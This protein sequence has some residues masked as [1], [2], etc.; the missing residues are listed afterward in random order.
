[1]FDSTLAPRSARSTGPSLAVK[2]GSGHGDETSES[3]MMASSQVAVIMGDLVETETWPWEME[4][5]SS[6]PVPSIL[7]FKLSNKDTY[8][9]PYV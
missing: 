8:L 4:K 3:L 7:N 2:V 6:K 1:M 9:P 5:N